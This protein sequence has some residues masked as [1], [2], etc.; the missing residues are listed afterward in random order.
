M[1]E[2]NTKTSRG[3]LFSDSDA[4]KW[5]AAILHPLASKRISKVIGDMSKL[6]LELHEATKRNLD[7][8]DLFTPARAN[9]TGA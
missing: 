4:N 2:N 1:I 6:G 5:A 8:L 7:Q 9:A 3:F